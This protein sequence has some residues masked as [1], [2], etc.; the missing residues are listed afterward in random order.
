MAIW[1]LEAATTEPWITMV[2]CSGMK[3]TSFIC[4]RHFA[5]FCP[6]TLIF[7]H[8]ARSVLHCSRRCLRGTPRSNL[9]PLQIDLISR[10]HPSQHFPCDCSLFCFMFFFFNRLT[11]IPCELSEI[12]SCLK[13]AFPM[14]RRSQKIHLKAAERMRPRSVGKVSI[15]GDTSS[16]KAMAI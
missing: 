3:A 6:S 9:E 16:K 4:I 5:I 1:Q 15:L 12:E 13:D 2:H 8:L 10:V 7:T 11:L 14:A